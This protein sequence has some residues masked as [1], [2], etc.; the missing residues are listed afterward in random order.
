MTEMAD[1][2]RTFYCSQFVHTE[3][4]RNAQACQG[5]FRVVGANGIIGGSKRI[6]HN[7]GNRRDHYV[8]TELPLRHDHRGWKPRQYYLT[9][10]KRWVRHTGS[11]SSQE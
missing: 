11:P 6:A 3:D 7:T 2:D 1:D 8:M 5:K 4:G 9:A 10:K